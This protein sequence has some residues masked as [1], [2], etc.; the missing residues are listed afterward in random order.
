LPLK[1]GTHSVTGFAALRVLAGLRWLRG[2]AFA[3]RP[4]RR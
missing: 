1:V 4:S 3:S 2:V